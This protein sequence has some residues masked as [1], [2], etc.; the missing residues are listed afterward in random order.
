[1][2]VL[3]VVIRILSNAGAFN[4]MG[5]A[6]TYI[7]NAVIQVGIM[8]LLPLITLKFVR[9]RSIGQTLEDCSFKG[10]SFKEFC[11]KRNAPIMT[12][13]TI[14]PIFVVPL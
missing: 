1:M 9:K 12:S 8:L 2:A 5:E 6:G 11:Q 3:F 4:F 10:I 14:V 13:R 7:V